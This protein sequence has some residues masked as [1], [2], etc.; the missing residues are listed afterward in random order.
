MDTLG[1][2]LVEVRKKRGLTQKKLAELLAITPTRLNYWEKD[3]REPD[4][5]MIKRIS[6]VLQIDPNFLIGVNLETEE[7]PC[8]DAL[9][10]TP[11]PSST[12]LEAE[13]ESKTKN[14]LEIYDQLD[15]KSKAL[16]L[17]IAKSLLKSSE[18]RE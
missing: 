3:K 4:I 9:E 14:I 18:S 13:N 6:D 5:S 7:S 12:V 10:N 1:K 17:D 2:R 8:S 11:P 15:E 16:M